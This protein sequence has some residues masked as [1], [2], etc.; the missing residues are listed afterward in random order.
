MCKCVFVK[1]APSHGD[2]LQLNKWACLQW[3]LDTHCQDTGEGGRLPMAG[4]WHKTGS[5]TAGSQRASGWEPQ[6]EATGTVPP[7]HVQTFP[8][9]GLSHPLQGRQVSHRNG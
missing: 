4:K 9:L 2:T 1:E 8:C 7:S 6:L 3:N 5:Q